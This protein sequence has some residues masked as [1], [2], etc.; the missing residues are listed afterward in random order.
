MT[1]EEAAL[2]WEAN[3]NKADSNSNKLTAGLL[4]SFVVFGIIGWQLTSMQ[5]TI[6]DMIALKPQI[7]TMQTDIKDNNVIALNPKIEQMRKDIDANRAWQENWQ[8]NGSLGIDIEQNE[9]IIK[10][11]EKVKNIESLKLDTRLTRMETMLSILFE[12]QIGKD[13]DDFQRNK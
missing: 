2:Q 3:K 12:K 6:N 5:T 10:L 1:P 9:K 7:T 11:E 4:V 13:Y 8:V